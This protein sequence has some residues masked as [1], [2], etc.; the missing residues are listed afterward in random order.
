MIV[1]QRGREI[2]RKEGEERQA[3]SEI[4]DQRE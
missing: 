1:L 4:D 2:R 3:E